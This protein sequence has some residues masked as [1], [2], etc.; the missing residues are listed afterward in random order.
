MQAVHEMLL[1]SWSASPGSG[2]TGVIRLFPATPWRWHN[3]SF[4]DLRAEGGHRVSARRENNATTWFRIVAGRNGLIRIRDNFGGR[5][6]NWNRSGVKRVNGNFEIE[7][8]AGT[9]IEATLSVPAEIPPAPANAAA[10]VKAKR[11]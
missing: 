8:K 4:E 11:R 10:P 9:T 7:C 5:V 3:A 2:D 6:I 1:Q